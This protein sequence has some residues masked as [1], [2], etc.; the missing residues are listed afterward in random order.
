MDLLFFLSFSD[1]SFQQQ[2]C[3]VLSC[4]PTPKKTK[5]K[6][7]FPP[8]CCLNMPPPNAT[9]PN[10]K[11][12]Y[13]FRRDDR[14]EFQLALLGM[15]K[16][17]LRRRGMNVE[18][19][20]TAPLFCT[21]A[22]EIAKGEFVGCGGFPY[23]QYGLLAGRTRSLG[24]GGGGPSEEGGSQK[25][26]GVGVEE[27]P[28]IFLN[29]SAPWS[30]FICGSQGSGKSHSLA[31]ILENCLVSHH[32]HLGSLPNPLTA[33]V[34][35]YDP[36][37]SLAGQ[38]CEAVYLCSPTVEVRVLVSP[39]SYHRMRKLYG[40]LKDLS[41]GCTVVI[42]PLILKEEYLNVERLMTF[43]AATDNNGEGLPLYM[44]SVL[45]VLRK[46]ALESNE[47]AGIDYRDFRT[48]VEMLSLSPGQ[49]IPLGL[50]LDLLEEFIE[51]QTIKKK[52]NP[53][54]TPRKKGNDWEPVS[55]RLTIIDLSCHFLDVSTACTLFD[56]HLGVFL[57]Q[58]LD[59]GRLVALDEAHKVIVI[60]FL[61]LFLSPRP[62]P[63]FPFDIPNL[64]LLTS[65]LYF[66]KTKP[67]LFSR[68]LQFMVESTGASK[69][70]ESLLSVI[71][72]QR[73]SACRII[74]ATQEPTI[75]PKLLDLCS[76]TLV[77]RFTSPDWFRTIKAHLFAAA[78]AAAEDSA[79][80]GVSQRAGSSMM[81]EIVELNVGE[82]LL[83]APSAML[84]VIDLKEEGE[85]KNGEVVHS[86]RVKKLGV[87]YLSVRIR[88]RVTVD[89]GKS[90]M[91]S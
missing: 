58:K 23:K 44:H 6:L 35:H 53:T 54:T 67:N 72:L 12:V 73:H 37:A 90:I 91:A 66:F 76:F 49:K 5:K 60:T 75:S 25:K 16:D 63:S 32:Q 82:A 30:A 14:A 24:G 87:E 1:Y 15:G 88:A 29:V 55:G 43:M 80:G 65:H 52:A 40:N 33:L 38:V 39:T 42:E 48:R 28:R 21:E 46:M 74:I 20:R 3:A 8:G 57:E 18:E 11:E 68:R 17:N 13:D 26:K 34:F 19:S 47:K 84:Q 77:H 50:R 31:C 83:F 22:A 71:R 45:R 85:K 79:G 10:D 64:Y 51:P 62:A 89:G 4:K 59:I 81:S 41:P 86:R 2:I 69:L 78:A 56:I 9:L 36:Q 27:D 70:T 61:A 7:N